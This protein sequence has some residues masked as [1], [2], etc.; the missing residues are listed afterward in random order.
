[1]SWNAFQIF[2]VHIA[3]NGRQ[4]SLLSSLLATEGHLGLCKAPAHHW[5]WSISG[6]PQLPRTGER[7]LRQPCISNS[8]EGGNAVATHNLR[9]SSSATQENQEKYHLQYRYKLFLGAGWCRYTSRIKVKKQNG[10]VCI[11]IYIYK[12][13]SANC[14]KE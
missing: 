5:S 12:H 9:E 6:H 3:S 11:Y 2:Q 10:D 1:M 7:H 8:L 13:S 4:T 14:K